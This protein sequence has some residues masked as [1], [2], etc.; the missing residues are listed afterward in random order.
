MKRI[1]TKRRKKILYLGYKESKLLVEQGLLNT[2]YHAGK[3]RLLPREGKLKKI[4]KPKRT[5][6][7][8]VA[9]L[10]NECG[11]TYITQALANYIR[12]N[13]SNNIRLIDNSGMNN[14]GH[15]LYQ[16]IKE[17]INSNINYSYIVIDMG[18]IRGRSEEEITEYKRANIKIMVSNVEDYYLRRLAA[19]IKEDKKASVKHAYIFNLVPKEQKRRVSK[20]MEA[21]EHYCLPIINKDNLSYEAQRIF[22]DILRRNRR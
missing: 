3:Q 13:V 20:L 11:C 5:Q 14:N 6:V 7:I 2:N 8:A 12:N 9:S 15:L 21:Y 4:P 17:L 1:K 18:N 19:Y 10:D 22:T 16:K